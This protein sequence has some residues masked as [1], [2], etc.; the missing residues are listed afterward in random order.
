MEY[1]M[2]SSNGGSHTNTSSSWRGSFQIS[3][4][5]YWFWVWYTFLI[6]STTSVVNPMSSRT[7]VRYR[8][9]CSYVLW[10]ERQY[11]VDILMKS[12]SEDIPF[13]LQ[14][15]LTQFSASEG[16]QYINNFIHMSSRCGSI[17]HRYSRNSMIWITMWPLN[18]GWSPQTTN[19][20][21][22]LGMFLESIKWYLSWSSSDAMVP[23]VES[24]QS[25]D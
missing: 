5:G 10:F 22:Y 20:C 2:T 24:I 14:Q 16:K 9:K 19:S 3:S 17:S 12:M 23:L 8:R 21:G 25:W 1:W 15:S 7:N 11:S 6:S 4:L 18:I 13:G